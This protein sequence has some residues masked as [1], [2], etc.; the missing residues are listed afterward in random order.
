M[1]VAAV[2]VNPAT[3]GGSWSDRN[4][5]RGSVTIASV[6]KHARVIGRGLPI[7]DDVEGERGMTALPLVRAFFAAY[8]TTVLLTRV[9]AWLR[10]RL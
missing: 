4:A 2:A 6:L 1:T 3:H 5:F 10:Y 7:K 8:D 9:I